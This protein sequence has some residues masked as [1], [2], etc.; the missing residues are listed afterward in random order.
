MKDV[1]IYRCL[2]VVSCISGICPFIL[3]NNM[4]SAATQ[5]IGW[6]IS[7]CLILL[8]YSGMFFFK[9]W[10]R[11]IFLLM[12]MMAFIV[13]FA[14]VGRTQSGIASYFYDL[15]T[16]TSGAIIAMSFY[17]ELKYRFI[18]IKPQSPVSISR[19]PADA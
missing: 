18:K 16:I 11:I 4:P 3:G 2:L 8:I 19:D 1:I 9:G 12:T 10:A 6:S 13:P 15:S 7:A 17:S 14:Y 5:I